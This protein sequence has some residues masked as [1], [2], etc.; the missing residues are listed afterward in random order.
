MKRSVWMSAALVLAAHAGWALDQQLV[1]RADA[2]LRKCVTYLTEQV[3]YRGGYGG[4]YLEDLSDQWGEGHILRHQIWLQPPGT[5]ATGEAFLAAWRATGDDFYLQAARQVADALV[6]GQLA[7]GGWDYV[8]DFS[9]AGEEAYY[10]RHNQGSAD[11]KLTSGANVG[12]FDDNTSQACLR[13]L[14]AVDQALEGQD[15]AVRDAVAA[16]L[17]W[18][19]QAQYEHGGFPQRYPLAR[20]GY[21]NFT[22]YNDENMYHIMHLLM[23]A[24]DQY[25]DPRLRQALERLGDFFLKSQLPEP[26]PVWAQQY[27]SDMRPAWARKFEPPSVTAGES[28]GVMRALITM[29]VYTGDEKYLEPIPRALEWYRRS[30]LPNGR[31]ARFYE[32]KTNRPLYF[33]FDNGTTYWLTYSDRDIPDHYSMNQSS[34]PTTVER[35]YNAIMAHGLANY[36]AANKP[37]ELTTAQKIAAAEALEA[38][39]REVLAAQTPNGVWVRERQGKRFIE[40]ERVQGNMRV[41]SDY[42][43]RAN[44]R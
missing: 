37:K 15:Q 39:V 4:S 24:L 6:W 3:S 23:A 44:D 20:R 1:A 9:R 2:A 16:G 17:A 10:Y 41:L 40:M 33:T 34:F 28:A 19:L 26:Q 38:K 8:V 31:W 22:T 14:M 13:L 35:D 25:Q 11:P 27:D 18:V 36:I 29:A 43:R 5:P 21:Q 7:C 42:L 30:Q 12:T 32:L